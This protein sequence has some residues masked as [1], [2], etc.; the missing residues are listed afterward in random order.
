MNHLKKFALM[1]CAI[2]CMAGVCSCEEDT[3][4]DVY[5][6]QIG[7]MSD[8]YT[9]NLLLQS[10]VTVSLAN[11]MAQSEQVL[12]TEKAAKEWFDGACLQVKDSWKMVNTIVSI[13]PDTWVELKLVNSNNAVVKAKKVK[14]EE[15]K[16]D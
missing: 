7:E 10:C 2:L 4:E 9:D 16:L 8:S 3:T 5:T 13:Q 12:R 6:I 11:Y 15:N 1:M 14:F